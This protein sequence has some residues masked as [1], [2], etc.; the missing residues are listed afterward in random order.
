MPKRS[1]EFTGWKIGKQR[2]ATKGEAD[3]QKPDW[4]KCF[5]I[6]PFG[7]KKDPDGNP[8]D[9]DKIYREFIKEA[10]A[11]LGVD[12]VRCDEIAETG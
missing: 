11:E 7:E 5:V 1:L 12:C 3:G 10:V 6:M 2:K 8:I 4:Q 9:F